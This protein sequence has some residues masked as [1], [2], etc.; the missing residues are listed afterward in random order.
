MSQENGTARSNENDAVRDKDQRAEKIPLLFADAEAVEAIAKQLIPEHHP[1]LS[2]ASVRYI[3][4]N[5]A[6][7]RSGTPVPGNVY[8]MSGKYRFLTGYDFVV[9]VALEV[10]NE[11]APNQ[12]KAL[13]DHLLTRCVG[14]EDETTGDYRWR[15]I[16]PAIQ[17]FPEVAERNGQW[18]E[19]LVD[20]EKAL[21]ARM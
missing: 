4:R 11:L 18:N 15:V 7:R 6:A 13:V 9:E 19:G 3:C 14:D 16:P 2:M 21:R 5:K 10:W 1:H 8:K 20:M 12:R 17:E